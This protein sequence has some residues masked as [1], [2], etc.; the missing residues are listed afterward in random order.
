[1]QYRHISLPALLISLA[2]GCSSISPEH[3]TDYAGER[4]AARDLAIPPDLT[5]TTLS[6]LF[7][8]PDLPETIP[9]QPQ[10]VVDPSDTHQT[11]TTTGKP[12]I[13]LPGTQDQ[14]WQTVLSF[15]QAQDVQLTEENQSLGILRTAWIED[16]SRISDDAVTRTLRSFLDRLYESD[17]RNQ[18][19]M[20]LTS[21]GNDR[22]RLSV[23]H[24]GTQQKIHYDIDGDIDKTEWIPRA[25]DPQRAYNLLNQLAG[26]F[27]ISPS[28]QPAGHHHDSR[29]QPGHGELAIADPVTEAWP[30]LAHALSQPVFR[31][32]Q[33]DQDTGR[34]VV[35]YPL[36]PAKKSILPGL[37]FR[38]SDEPEP[39]EQYQII[40]QPT[41]TGAVIQ[42]RNQ[43]DQIVHNVHSTRL[44]SQIADYFQAPP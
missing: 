20:R 41:Q 25:P 10:P 32:Q 2:T 40:L 35:Q 43:Q 39:T 29:M 12:H 22:T 44:L 24:Y 33:Q 18:Y 15:W 38:I 17:Q 26:Y 6:P 16:R 34:F 23:T 4:Q 31:I 42:V 8:V 37:T 36:P 27:N 3:A 19:L 5:A 9:D 7:T 1:M 14:V 13:L 28:A 21:A 11:V 30:L